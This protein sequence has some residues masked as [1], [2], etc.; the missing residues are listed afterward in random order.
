MNYQI[1]Y[2]CSEFYNNIWIGILQNKG[3]YTSYLAKY[4]LSI[5]I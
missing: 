1:I 2:W 5:M 4:F 3:I